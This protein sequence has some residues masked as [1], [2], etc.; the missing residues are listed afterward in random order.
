MCQAAA[1]SAKPSGSFRPSL[2]M[3]FKSEP[4]GFAVNMRPALKFR[5]K[6]PPQV[7]PL[8]ASACIGVDG[9]ALM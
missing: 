4:S 1:S 8:L 6:S 5:K 2:T 7:C 9:I 3:V